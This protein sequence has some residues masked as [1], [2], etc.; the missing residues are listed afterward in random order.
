MTIQEYVFELLST[1]FNINKNELTL[2][3][4][5]LKDLG[6]DELD[7]HEI[8]FDLETEFEVIISDVME[9]INTIGD[10]INQTSL[11]QTI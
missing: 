11:P 3:T 5:I 9:E 2:E 10:L 8:I 1:Q 6:A 7:I 4:Q